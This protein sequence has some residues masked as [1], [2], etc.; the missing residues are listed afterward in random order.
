MTREEVN[1]QA[2]TGEMPWDAIFDCSYYRISQ[3]SLTTITYEVA[4]E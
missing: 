2:V 4:N 1:T 3:V